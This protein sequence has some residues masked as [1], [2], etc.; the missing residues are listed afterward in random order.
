LDQPLQNAR[1]GDYPA[2][3][4]A[5]LAVHRGNAGLD[6]REETKMLQ[7]S[8]ALRLRR[9]GTILGVIVDGSIS[10]AL[11][12]ILEVILRGSS[13]YSLINHHRV[14]TSK[15]LKA[16]NVRQAVRY[17]V[18]STG[19]RRRVVFLAAPVHP[20]LDQLVNAAMRAA[21]RS[22]IKF[23][24]RV[25]KI[26][27]APIPATPGRKRNAP[28]APP[29]PTAPAAPVSVLWD[30]TVYTGRPDLS[31]VPEGWATAIITGI[32]L[33]TGEVAAA[34]PAG[35]VVIN[36]IGEQV[37]DWII[38]RLGE[39]GGDNP[40]SELPPTPPMGTGPND[41]GISQGDPWSDDG[42]DSGQGGNDGAGSSD[43]GG[44]SPGEPTGGGAGGAGHYPPPEEL[45]GD[46]DAFDRWA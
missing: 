20:S 28:P 12:R 25:N 33:A 23:V 36:F 30:D 1:I 29:V 9:K 37:V 7:A 31:I 14:R 42:A 10:P 2:F 5:K 18:G 15:D 6:K 32:I 8:A 4:A 16:A 26:G 13:Q 24:V 45:D 40:P 11:G 38:D 35:E 44:W 43:G 27:A 22:W 19:R 17:E 46:G 41:G 39:S 21:V 3:M 34:V